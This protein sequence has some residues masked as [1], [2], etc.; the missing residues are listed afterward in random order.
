MRPDPHIE[1]GAKLA[2]IGCVSDLEKIRVSQREA[3]AGHLRTLLTEKHFLIGRE[4]QSMDFRKS[5]AANVNKIIG[6]PVVTDVLV[7]GLHSKDLS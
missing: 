3:I 2:L 7:Y 1:L 6:Q 4:T 5:F